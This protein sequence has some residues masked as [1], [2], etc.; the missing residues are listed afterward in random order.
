MAAHS[1]HLSEGAL[2]HLAHRITLR[3]LVVLTTL[4]AI[5][6]A[7][8][9]AFASSTGWSQHK[10]NVAAV[11]WARTHPHTPAYKAKG[12]AY[13]KQLKKRPGCKFAHL[14]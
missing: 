11:T 5:L 6:I 14:P 13:L 8:T 10:C 9:A 12:V 1:Q 2:S 3:L 7:T 4:A